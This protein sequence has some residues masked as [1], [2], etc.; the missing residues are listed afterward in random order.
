MDFKRG[1]LGNWNDDPL[2]V[3]EG[4]E[5]TLAIFIKRLCY[6]TSRVNPLLLLTPLAKRTREHW[7]HTVRVGHRPNNLAKIYIY[8]YTHQSKF[9]PLMLGHMS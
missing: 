6:A 8:I 3:V 5:L 9:L 7:L 4:S 1:W 2:L